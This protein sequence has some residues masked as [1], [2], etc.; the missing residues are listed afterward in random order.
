MRKVLAMLA[1]AALLFA[2][3]K[4]SADEKTKPATYNT[5]RVATDADLNAS[6]LSVF[7]NGA[8]LP[9]GRGT[10]QEGA[11]IYQQQCAACHGD[12][13]EGRPEFPALVGGRG[14][15]ASPAP[16]LTVGSYWPY[17]T[18]VFDYIRRAMPYGSPGSLTN[19]E[20]YAVTAWLL[21]TNEI[22]DSKQELNQANLATISMPN[23][24]GFVRDPRPDV[25]SK[26]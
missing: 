5:G 13:G 15:L 12:K 21:H 23:R 14:T 6:D 9:Q 4:A 3:N 20:V 7:P 11:T 24:N 22:I 8:G 1:S 17:A 26:R 25:K 16:L 18:S 2:I 10:V 19:D